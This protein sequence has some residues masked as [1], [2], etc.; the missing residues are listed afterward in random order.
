MEIVKLPTV[1]RKIIY[2]Y[3]YTSKIKYKLKY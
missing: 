2:E 1:T 3:S